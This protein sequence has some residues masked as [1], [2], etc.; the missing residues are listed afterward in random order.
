MQMD[1]RV[2]QPKWSCARHIAIAIAIV[3]VIVIVPI[4]LM[5]WRLP[6]IFHDFPPIL[7]RFTTP[8]HPNMAHPLSA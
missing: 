3:N 7:Q 8:P 2:H 4:V 5:G 6:K 1:P